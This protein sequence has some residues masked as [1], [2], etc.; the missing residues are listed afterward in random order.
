MEKERQKKTFLNA[1][2]SSSVSCSIHAGIA[3][4]MKSE[5][6]HSNFLDALFGNE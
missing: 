6:S 3:A 5:Y 2:T 4:A 1:M